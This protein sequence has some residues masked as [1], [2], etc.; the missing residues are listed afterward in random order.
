MI[1]FCNVSK[2][3]GTQIVLQDASFRINTG[4]QA[5][6]VGPNGTGKST[7]AGI[8]AGDISPDSGTVQLPANTQIGLLRQQIA[9]S[10]LPM[11]LLAFAESGATS[12]QTIEEQ[13]LD[14]EQQLIAA[15]GVARTRLLE[16]LGELQTQFEHAGGYE[17]RHRT[18]AALDG[19]GF[20]QQE[21]NHPMRTFSGGWQMR[22]ALARTLIA[23]PDVLLLDEP[24]NYLDLP[25]VEW[26]QRFLRTYQGTLLLISHDRYLLN[27]LT[28]ITIEVANAVTER[29][30]GNYDRYVRDRAAR[31]EAR[32][33][34]QKNLARKIEKAEQFV[35]RFRY[36]ATKATQVKSREKMIA[37][38]D[39]VD[40]P[41]AV[42][43]K[44]T[45]RI[46]PPPRSGQ[47]I[48]R[49][50]K[51][52]HSYD[53]NR[54]VLKDIDLRIDRGAKIA[55]VGHNGLGKTTL[56]RLLAGILQP[57]EGRRVLG[58]NIILGYQSQEFADTMNP[59]NSVF[60]TV[61][62]VA[63]AHMREQA[64][65]G[66]LGGFGFSGDAIEKRV[67]VLSGGEK[68]RLAFARL[69]VNPPN[70]LLLDE[71]T[72]HLDIAARE[73]LEEA[74]QQYEGT[75]CIVSHDVTFTER[76]ATSIIT[77]QPPGIRRFPGTYA[78]F[79]DRLAQEQQPASQPNNPSDA[80]TPISR[81]ELR[82]QRAAVRQIHQQEVR[83]L[84]R[85]IAQIERQIAIFEDEQTKILAA[86]SQT[87]PAID[88]ETTNRR[89]QLIQS[90][91]AAYTARWEQ[92]AT[93]LEQHETDD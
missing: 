21:L 68:V 52:G 46:P 1:D 85:Q 71:P 44:G 51:A 32:E 72:T 92:T 18:E 8:I 36:Q 81:K 15:N 38:M 14:T 88:F 9:S 30:T 16:H 74:L 49:L 50:E 65:R 75:L 4:E 28:S 79:R 91:L 78:E 73:T 89:L 20:S 29:Y 82:K 12:L 58:H 56:L 61:K 54:W 93:A 35:N 70:F 84:R 87:E 47:E 64:I 48:V 53:G 62:Q 7:I 23:D 63:P 2:R 22:A 76:V 11:P 66:L 24:S 33:A 42:R 60:E 55:L 39:T 77:M 13:I 26:L 17:R 37:R 19:L 31:V 59:V 80:D 34:A 40:V 90:E 25:A 6:L 5:G 3:Y 45:I 41:L 43:S 67:S 83:H 57:G 69:L 86:L 10:H 27:S